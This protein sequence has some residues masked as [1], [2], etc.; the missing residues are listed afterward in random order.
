M[1]KK[2]LIARKTNQLAIPNFPAQNKKYY[3]KHPQRQR[4]ESKFRITYSKND[5]LLDMFE[6][7]VGVP[8]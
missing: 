7:A 5:K 6:S 4:E 8:K 2:T 3:M 1:R